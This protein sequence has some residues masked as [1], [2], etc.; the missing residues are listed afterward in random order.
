M[1]T[2]ISVTSLIIGIPVLIALGSIITY[3]IER[4]RSDKLWRRVLIQRR[5]H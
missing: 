3:L 5:L 4:H 2:Q 1:E